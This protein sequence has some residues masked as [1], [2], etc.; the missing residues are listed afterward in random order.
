MSKST[1]E[2]QISIEAAQF[3]LKLIEWSQRYF[4]RA[5]DRKNSEEDA[6]L[7]QLGVS[8]LE[9]ARH[10]LDSALKKPNGHAESESDI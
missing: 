9:I 8:H 1:V 2:I 5:V 10:A 4:A 7:I 6:R 3:L